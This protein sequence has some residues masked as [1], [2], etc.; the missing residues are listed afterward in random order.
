MVA[1]RSLAWFHV[2]LS[3]VIGA[4]TQGCGGDD[5]SNGATPA[6]DGGTADVAADGS[7]P[8]DGTADGTLPSE[9]GLDGAAPGLAPWIVFTS[10][11]GTTPKSANKLA[12]A[13]FEL[14]SGPTVMP[15]WTPYESGY[16]VALNAGKTGNALRLQ[17]A[18]GDSQAQGALQT[19]ELNQATARP[20]HFSGWSKAEGLTGDPDSSASIYLDI[21]YKTKAEDPQNGCEK[22]ADETC[23]LWGRVPRPLFDTG[24]HDW[25][26]R[27]GFA[28]PAYPIKRVSFYVLLRGDHT[29]TMLF[30]DVALEEVEA[31]IVEFDGTLVASVKPS[32]PTTGG[33]PIPLATGDGLGVTLW[34][35]GGAA[36]AVKLDGDDVFHADF[37]YGSGFMLHEADAAE[38]WAPGGA[39]KVEGNGAT[40]TAE[41]AP[42]G[43]K[44]AAIYEAG[45]D[46]I[47]VRAEVTSTTPQDRAVTVY[48]ALPIETS[49]WWWGDDI[50]RMRPVGQVA[51]L[52]N[53]TSY[54]GEGSLGATGKF[55][56]YP[57]ATVFDDTRG[58][59]IGYP[60]DQTRIARLVHNPVTRQLYI[61]FDVGLAQDAAKNPSRASVELVLYRTRPT[62]ADHGFRAAL[63]G[64]HALH[65]EHFGRRIPPEEE[66][67]W[68]AFADLSKVQNGA[69]ESLDDFHIGFHEGSVSRVAFDDQHGIKTFRYVAEPASTWLQITD[70][71]VDPHDKQQTAAW[72]EKLYQSGDA[73]QKA[74]AEKTLSSAAYNRDGTLAY[75]AYDDGPS[76]CK[77][78]CALFYLNPDPDVSEPPYASNQASYFW[79]AQTKETYTTTPG[80]DGEYIDSFLMA[81]KLGNFRRSHFKA[82]DIPLTFTY[83]APRAVVTPILFSTLEFTRWL[84][85]QLP[86][87]KYFI[88]NSLLIGVPWGAELFDFMG[89][90][91]DW[92]KQVSGEY[93]VV[94]EEDWLL[95]YRRSMSAKRP[96]G[97]LMNTDFANMSK[98]MVERY[99]RI[100]LFYGI[101]PSM[102]SPN[103][104]DA[105]YFETPE[106]Y[107][108]DR[109][110]F[111]QYIPLIRQLN[112]GGW[113]PMTHARTS[114]EGVYVERFGSWPDTLHFTLRNT[115]EQAVTVTLTI[116]RAA[117][118]V[119][120]VAKGD[121]LLSSA[122]DVTIAEQASE[123]TVTIPEGEVEAIRV[124]P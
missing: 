43:M 93:R 9:G 92:V 59:A 68:V 110:L 48:Y 18:A 11:G 35:E 121:V 6:G 116:D 86:Q 70:S 4:V 26:Y 44:L 88:A 120:G 39:V 102:F 104:S 41:V 67:I 124:A 82:A 29:G 13:D 28:V 113:E 7:V 52:T 22:T 91:I 34:S 85:P 83:D 77:G 114:H 65:P 50:R 107:Q 69:G 32:A 80:L 103:A 79:N 53:Q 94:P 64:F 95:S 75:E 14:S 16:A 89:Q 47:R 72:L 38:W 23:S 57:F 17:R 55:S 33:D 117:L 71:A 62:G 8:L 63:Q 99:M 81:A 73:S 56:R 96:Y 10:A 3:L 109:S 61:A 74:K 54:W 49:G 40:H 106:L 100:C 36:S 42:L 98:D 118:G 30:D 20:I 21:A 31:D 19:V 66:G 112:S 58:M 15:S 101:Y 90:E 76:W 1:A 2:S 108:R 37:G 87:G 25:Q 46:R 105:N 119:T 123:V 24:T 27:D 5:A 122:P 60:L 45:A 97:F 51:E 115:T 111:K 12:N 84:R 78:K